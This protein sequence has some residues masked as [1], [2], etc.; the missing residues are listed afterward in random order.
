M[1]NCG[2][3]K[4]FLRLFQPVHGRVANTLANVPASDDGGAPPGYRKP[5]QE[6]YREAQQ[7]VPRRH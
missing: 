3:S 2:H 1:T 5:P 7:A 6:F 4:Y